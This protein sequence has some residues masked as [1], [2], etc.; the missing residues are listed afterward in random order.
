MHPFIKHL[1]D[2]HRVQRGLA[3]DL[4]KAHAT[5]DRK[6]LRERLADELLPHMAG[7]EDSIFSLMRASGDTA[8]E[9]ALEALQEHHVSRLVLRELLDLGLDSNVFSAKAAV[10]SELTD[11]HTEEE[12]SE[13][14]PWLEKH[15]S[16][17]KLDGLFDDYRK[18]EKAAAK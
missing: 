4:E 6:R 16:K 10:L 18:S 11:H 1:V 14:F 13:H 8:E 9:K 3:M 2:D 12:E 7:E 17:E 15:A 5:E